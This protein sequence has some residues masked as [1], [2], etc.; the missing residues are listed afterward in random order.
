MTSRISK[1]YLIE[2][3]S[4]CFN[5]LRWN[6]YFINGQA[7]SALLSGLAASELWL[8][9]IDAFYPRLMTY[10]TNNKHRVMIIPETGR[11]EIRVHYTSPVAERI[12]VAH[13]LAEQLNQLLIGD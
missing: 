13:Q 5:A 9:N 4:T 7:T 11:I 1:D 3:K 12:E 8:E 2:K 10:S 6:F